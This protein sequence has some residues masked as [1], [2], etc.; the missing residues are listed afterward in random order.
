MKFPWFSPDLQGNLPPQYTDCKARG[1]GAA[2]CLMG[3]DSRAEGHSYLPREGAWFQVQ[4]QVL[5]MPRQP[6]PYKKSTPSKCGPVQPQGKMVWRFLKN[7]NHHMLQQAHSWARIPRKPYSRKVHAPQC[8]QQDYSQQPG[9][10][11]RP[12]VHRQRDGWRGRGTYTP[13]NTTHHER[14]RTNATRT[15]TGVTRD[16]YTK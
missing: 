10:G 11:S 5:L 2:R 9:Q 14:E 16:D 6:S 7:E 3:E 12:K 8:P 1:G 4:A 15:N 13:W